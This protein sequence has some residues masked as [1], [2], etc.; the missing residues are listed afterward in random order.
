MPTLTR[1]AVPLLPLSAL[2][3]RS[4]GLNQDVLRARVLKRDRASTMRER[5][6]IRRPQSRESP[7]AQS[8]P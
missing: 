1:N 4:A 8:P 3:H 6:P 5:I 2:V 7:D